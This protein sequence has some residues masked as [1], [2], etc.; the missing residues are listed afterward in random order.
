MA[1]Y[2]LGLKNILKMMLIILN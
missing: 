1:N 2:Q